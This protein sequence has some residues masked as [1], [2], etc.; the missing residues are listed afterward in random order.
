MTSLQI[1]TIEADTTTTFSQ[2]PSISATVSAYPTIGIT[3][4][5]TTWVGNAL[6]SSLASYAT[7][8]SLSAYATVASLSAYA[9]VASLSAYATVASLSA[10]ATV[11]SLASYAQLSSANFT[12]LSRGSKRAITTTTAQNV[13]CQIG[14]GTSATGGVTNTFATPFTNC[15]CVICQITTGS[16]TNSIKTSSITAS[17]FIATSGSVTPSFDY[18]AWGY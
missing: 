12:L 10:Y 16:T 14:S 5:T 2:V 11:A 6:T 4:P 3:I 7:V 1:N 8:A 15:L 18:I 13:Y 17:N 9:T